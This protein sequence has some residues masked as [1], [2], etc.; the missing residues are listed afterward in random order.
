MR[1]DV[2]VKSMIRDETHKSKSVIAGFPEW[3]NSNELIQ[4]Q[5]QY[6][7]LVLKC[8][9]SSLSNFVYSV[10]SERSW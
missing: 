8:Y 10:K 1:D 3:Q 2:T 7:H 5:Q 4:I 6:H 9:F